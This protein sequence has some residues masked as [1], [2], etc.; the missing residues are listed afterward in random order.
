MPLCCPDNSEMLSGCYRKQCP[1]VTEICNCTFIEK[2][3]K[4]ILDLKQLSMIDLISIFN[5]RNFKIFFNKSRIFK[6]YVV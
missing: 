5:R 6:S 2:Y 4:K 1:D 3:G